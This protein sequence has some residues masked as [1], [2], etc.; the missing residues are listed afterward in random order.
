MYGFELFLIE[1]HVGVQRHRLAAI[2]TGAYNF[3]KQ[4]F[5]HFANAGAG[6]RRRLEIVIAFHERPHFAVGFVD[7]SFAFV[8]FVGAHH[9]HNVVNAGAVHFQVAFDFVY[10]VVQRVKAGLVR[11]VEHQQ[12]ALRVLVEFVAY[13]VEYD[14]ARHVEYVQLD[15]LLANV[16]L[17]HAVID[18]DRLQILRHESLLTVALDY[19]TFA[20]FTVANTYYFYFQW[21]FHPCTVSKVNNIFSKIYL[22]SNF[23]I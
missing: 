1:R 14:V 20:H 2:L 8:Y 5:E 18:A 7:H 22:K 21:L 15:F 16:N 19:A 11:D 3:A 6:R 23:Y 4:R 10:P 17:G 13:L 12:R 9:K